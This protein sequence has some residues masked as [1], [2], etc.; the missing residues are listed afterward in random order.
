MKFSDNG[1]LGSR[2]KGSP[3]VL[4]S[5]KTSQGY[6][7]GD[8]VHL[9]EGLLKWK[10]PRGPRLVKRPVVMNGKVFQA[11]VGAPAYI[12]NPSGKKV[13]PLVKIE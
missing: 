4:S 2:T 1:I 7:W 8:L 5:R 3:V 12:L 6:P 10:A 9:P 11:I 13:D